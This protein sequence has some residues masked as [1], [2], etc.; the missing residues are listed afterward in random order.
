MGYLSKL[1]LVIPVIH[2]VCSVFVFCDQAADELGKRHSSKKKK[3]LGK[4]R[5]L[6]KGNGRE[7][8]T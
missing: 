7:N 2:L 4:R 5:S 3:K 6:Q 8:C 1:G